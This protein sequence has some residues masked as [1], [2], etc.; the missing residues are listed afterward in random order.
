MPSDDQDKA[1]G[2]LSALDL[3]KAMADVENRAMQ[4]VFGGKQRKASQP[5]DRDWETLG[6]QYA[7]LR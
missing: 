7:T 2:N 1:A 3:M 5:Y 6:T 4:K